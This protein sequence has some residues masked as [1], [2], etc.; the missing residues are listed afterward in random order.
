LGH[1]FQNL[2]KFYSIFWSHCSQ[3]S[4]WIQPLKIF[5]IWSKSNLNSKQQTSQSGLGRHE[6]SF[7]STKN[8]LAYWRQR[9]RLTKWTTGERFDWPNCLARL[10]TTVWPWLAGGRVRSRT[11]DRL[12]LFFLLLSDK[13]DEFRAW[14]QRGSGTCAIILFATII[15]SNL[16]VESGKSY[17]RGSLSTV[18]L[19][20]LTSSFFKLKILLTSFTKQATLMR[21]STVMSLPS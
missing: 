19:L 14:S 3:Q 13:M 16:R 18:D 4:L 1:F 20:V 15:D 8:A 2:A 6:K 17:L 10:C 12:N 9:K 5:S 21:R 11:G 7:F